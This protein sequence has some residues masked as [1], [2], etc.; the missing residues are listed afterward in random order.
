MRFDEAVVCV[1]VQIAQRPDAA[2]E[3][4]LARSVARV[5]NDVLCPGKVSRIGREWRTVYASRKSAGVKY[6]VEVAC[7]HG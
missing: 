4:Y 3:L 2:P 6:A 5:H 1:R 7:R